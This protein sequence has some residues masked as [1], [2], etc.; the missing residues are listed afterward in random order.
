[1]PM[2]FPGDLATKEKPYDSLATMWTAFA[3]LKHN[4]S[5]AID[6]DAFASSVQ[7]PGSIPSHTATTVT[8]ASILQHRRPARPP[9]YDVLLV[10][11]THSRRDPVLVDYGLWPFDDR[12]YGIVCTVVNNMF[13]TE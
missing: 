2:P 11:A 13:L 3:N 5:P 4:T 6:G 8:A 1:M 12:V 10:S 7:T 9:T